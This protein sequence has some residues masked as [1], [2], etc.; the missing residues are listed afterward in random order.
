MSDLRTEKVDAPEPRNSYVDYLIDLFEVNNV[1]H[2]VITYTPG[3]RYVI[4]LTGHNDFILTITHVIHNAGTYYEMPC[5][6]YSFHRERGNVLF[7]SGQV[8]QENIELYPEE[9]HDNILNSAAYF[10]NS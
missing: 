4:K 2:T 5:Y 3:S 8:S 1:E 7:E 9:A 10:P 6:A